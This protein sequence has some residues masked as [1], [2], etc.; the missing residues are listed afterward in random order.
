MTNAGGATG[1]KSS[2]RAEC[3]AGRLKACG[4]A[5]DLLQ[6]DTREESRARDVQVLDF[7]C[8]KGCA[9]K[10][11]ISMPNTHTICDGGLK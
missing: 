5:V 8:C 6:C 3:N 1:L 10:Y 9:F 2:R 11:I 4:G 7:L